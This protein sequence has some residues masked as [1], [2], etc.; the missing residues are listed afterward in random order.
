MSRFADPRA[1]RTVQLGP[2]ECPGTPHDE[3]WAKVRS[4]LSATDLAVL[5]RL[6]GM[7]QDEAVEALLPYIPEW[8][9]LG[10]D[11]EVAPI[12]LA[13][14]SGLKR[15]TSA[16]IGDTVAEVIKE[17]LGLP[18]SP[19]APSPASPRGSGSRT[20]TKRRTTGT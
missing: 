10:D 9:L 1:T 17:N 7:E 5:L 15:Q 13:S 8:N 16:L 18:N 14:V 20:P 6:D 12:D 11:G 3:D 4:D 2:C 19:A